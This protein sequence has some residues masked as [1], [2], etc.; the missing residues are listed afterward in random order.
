MQAHPALFSSGAGSTLAN[1]ERI[2]CLSA[3]SKEG[4]CKRRFP[5]LPALPLLLSGKDPGGIF[6]VFLAR[7]EMLTTHMEEREFDH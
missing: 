3:S 2:E 1:P 4:A 7:H 6:P 5:L